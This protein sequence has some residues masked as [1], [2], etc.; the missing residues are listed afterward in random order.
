MA[1]KNLKTWAPQPQNVKQGLY[2]VE[3]PG[4]KRVD[5][6]TVPRINARAK[7]GL[8]KTLDN[9]KIQT[10]WDIVPFASKKYAVFTSIWGSR[11]AVLMVELGTGKVIRLRV[12]EEQASLILLATDG[13]SLVLVEASTMMMSSSTKMAGTGGG[14]KDC[15]DG[16]SRGNG[17]GSVLLGTRE[18]DPSLNF[19][20]G[21]REGTSGSKLGLFLTT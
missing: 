8:K 2:T 6:E 20:D 9:G 13:K 1:P 19:F 18:E 7:D 11:L 15:S 16:G 12:S 5:G 10:T 4:Y 21:T 3:A 14:G 17:G